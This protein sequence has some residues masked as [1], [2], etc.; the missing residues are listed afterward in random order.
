MQRLKL[1]EKNEASLDSVD[2]DR[3]KSK[4]K[5]ETLKVGREGKPTKNKTKKTEERKSG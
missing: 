2:F 4:Q 3:K 5:K 1:K